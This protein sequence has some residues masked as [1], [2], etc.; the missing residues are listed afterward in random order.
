MPTV[1]TLAYNEA[2]F[3]QFMIDHYRTRFPDCPIVVYD[4]QS[5][6]DTVKIAKDNGCQVVSFDT[7]DKFDELTNI[8]IKKNVWKSA[9]TDWVVVC[10]I[11]ELID[12]SQEDLVREAASGSSIIRFE[13]YDMVNLENNSDWPSI[14]YGVRNKLYDKLYLFNRKRTLSINY[15]PGAHF[16]GPVGDVTYSAKVYPAYHYKY[17]SEDYLIARYDVFAARLSDSNRKN[18]WTTHCLI[19]ETQ[20]REDFLQKRKIAQKVIP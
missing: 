20:I 14:K 8:E 19:S 10:D 2:P 4:N 13:A 11:D 18:G 9:E 7:Q 15:L 6:D 3:I 17:L 1:F 16:A 5:T 12:I